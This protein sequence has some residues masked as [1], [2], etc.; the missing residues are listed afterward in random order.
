MDEN[1]DLDD[2]SSESEPEGLNWDSVGAYMLWS[3][4]LGQP[5]YVPYQLSASSYATEQNPKYE[6]FELYRY[7][8]CFV[9]I[10]F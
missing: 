7:Q 9:N 5:V 10:E 2:S 8:I 6:S 4:N 3:I 1:E